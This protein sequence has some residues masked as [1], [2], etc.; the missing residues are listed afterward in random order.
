MMFSAF[1]P[2]PL[3]NK[4]LSQVPVQS[5]IHEAVEAWLY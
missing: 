5:M 2:F 3:D 4:Q 1:D